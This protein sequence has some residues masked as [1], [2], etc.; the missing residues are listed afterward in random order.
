MY[1]ICFGA[2]RPTVDYVTVQGCW[3]ESRSGLQ[4]LGWSAQMPPVAGLWAHWVVSLTA[5]FNRYQK[6]HRRI[7]SE[8]AV[9]R[10]NNQ[11][12]R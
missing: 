4:K 3:P 12:I 6:Y 2:M 10:E 9:D 7:S 8:R 5:K 1:S 11:N